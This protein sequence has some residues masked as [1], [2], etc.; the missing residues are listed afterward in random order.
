MPVKR[1][2]KKRRLDPAAELEA[3][4]GAFQSHY[5]YFGELE[6]IGVDTDAQGQPDRA[7]VEAAWH[8]LGVRFLAEKADPVL[9]TPW[10]VLELR[11]P[12]HAG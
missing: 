2:H 7:V 4:S 12:R 5:T 1:R 9:G 8:R 11:E 6:E 10:A 3:W